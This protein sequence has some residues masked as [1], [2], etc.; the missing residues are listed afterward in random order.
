MSVH[1]LA[2][3]PAG[4]PAHPQPAPPQAPRRPMGTTEL[5]DAADKGDTAKVARLLKEH[6]E[7]AKQTNEVPPRRLRPSPSRPLMFMMPSL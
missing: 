7:W 6:L 4:A 5:H 1:A 2:Y 3:A